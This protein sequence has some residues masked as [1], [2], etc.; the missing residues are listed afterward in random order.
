METLY[1]LGWIS[2]LHLLL[3]AVLLFLKKNNGNA[4]KILALFMLIFAGVH[5]DDI[6]V[7]SRIAWKYHYINEGAHFLFFFLG[8]L[9]LQYTAYMCGASINWK[10]HLWLHLLPFAFAGFYVIYVGTKPEEEL[11]LFYTSLVHQPP[12]IFLLLNF[13]NALQ[14]GIYLLWSLKLIFS[15]NKK[16]QGKVYY[17]QLNLN[18]LKQLTFYLLLTCYV[19]APVLLW[20]SDTDTFPLYAFQP[21]MTTVIYL[22]LFYKS[23]TFPGAEYEK[24]IIREQ[25]QLIVNREVYNELA[26]GIAQISNLAER[27]ELQ[28]T[29]SREKLKQISGNAG[30]LSGKLRIIIE[31]LNNQE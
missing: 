5:I 30:S 15:Y 24:K 21:V 16:L 25:E 3:F 31:K 18:W 2:M 29:E 22:M 28:N 14:M 26:E 12:L 9:Y 4:N 27:I 1:Y 23:I 7:F 19:I 20:L 8:P 11:K 13:F 6:L 10:K 17:N